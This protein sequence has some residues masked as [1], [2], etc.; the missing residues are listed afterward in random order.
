MVQGTIAELKV[1]V[2]AAKAEVKH[3]KAVHAAA[4]ADY[5]SEITDLEAKLHKAQVELQVAKDRHAANVEA[6]RDETRF[7]QAD[8]EDVVT[9]LQSTADALEVQLRSEQNANTRLQAELQLYQGHWHAAEANRLA[10]LADLRAMKSKQGSAVQDAGDLVL[11]THGEERAEGAQIIPSES[12]RAP[13]ARSL[14]SVAELVPQTTPDP[15]NQPESAKDNGTPDALE[16]ILS[17]HTQNGPEYKK[18]TALPG[19]AQASLLAKYHTDFSTLPTEMATKSEWRKHDTYKRYTKPA[20]REGVLQRRR[21]LHCAYF[22]FR[23]RKCPPGL[24][25]GTTQKVGK[26]CVR[27]VLHENKYKL[28]FYRHSTNADWREEKYWRG[29]EA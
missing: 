1:E 17:V 29:E 25:C 7:T 26:L 19:S 5:K 16:M 3:T 12:D 4:D 14:D 13:S 28:C 21:C 24:A 11:G 27:L 23:G 18:F 10:T 22:G 2:V 20:M 15:P 9:E 8:H 6:L